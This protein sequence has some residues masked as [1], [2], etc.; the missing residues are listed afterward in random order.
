MIYALIILFFLIALVA[1]WQVMQF[2]MTQIQKTMGESFKA[3]SFDILEKSSRT[4]L[5]L[6]K[7]RCLNR[8]GFCVD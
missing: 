7:D 3:L 2:K 4:F 8:F 1:V 6:A 5:D